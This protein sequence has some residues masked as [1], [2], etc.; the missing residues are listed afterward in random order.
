MGA[1]SSIPSVHSYERLTGPS[2]PDWCGISPVTVPCLAFASAAFGGASGTFDARS[3]RVCVGNQ[4]AQPLGLLGGPWFL[5]EAEDF[6]DLF[7]YAARDHLPPVFLNLVYSRRSRLPRGI[8]LC[9]WSGR[10]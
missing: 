10:G 8:A 3:R 6:D 9:F 7:G 4:L 5:P 1:P 2:R